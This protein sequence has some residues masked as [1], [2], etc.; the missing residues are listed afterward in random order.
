MLVAA[1]G[2]ATDPYGEDA[3]E[4][5]EEWADAWSSGDQYDTVRFYTTDVTVQS[6]LPDST[7]NYPATFGEGAHHGAGR[8]WLANWLA[9]QTQPH[10][11]SLDAV[12]IDESSAGVLLGVDDLDAVT[13]VSLEM[14][15][16][17]IRSHAAL[18]W[19]D[20]HLPGGAPDP[21][22]AWLDKL[23]ATYVA[24]LDT[25]DGLFIGGEAETLRDAS[26]ALAASKSRTGPA[27]FVV[28]QPDPTLAAIVVE[29]GLSGCRAQL[30][31]EL[32]IAERQ[33]VGEHVMPSIETARRCL[34]DRLGDGGW[35]TALP[36]PAALDQQVT[37][38]VTVSTGSD[39]T[40]INGSRELEEL[41]RWGMSRF[42]AAGLD[43]PPI[44]SVTFGPLPACEGRQGLVAENAAGSPS[45]ILCTDA[46]RACRP[47]RE[48]C[49]EFE[50]ATRFGLL[51]E[52]GHAWLLEHVDEE[53]QDAFLA[54]RSLSTW[55]DTAV[56]WHMRG[57]EHAADM[58][59]WGLM[60]ESLTLT[61]LA[62]PSCEVS[63]AGFVLLADVTA[64]VTCEA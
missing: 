13:F 28:P 47:D 46:D 10:D 37:G 60:D 14:R 3:E 48:T 17:G 58:V 50:V 44:D 55:D 22:L 62:D 30:A 51:H 56:P 38:A 26:I 6:A 34:E 53:T 49:T 31:V 39:I 52:L 15:D 23:I 2:Q 43:P 1:C 8:A 33:I 61:R 29:G 41:V 7:L 32:E 63:A 35:W 21:R 25:P 16:E 64:L 11:R 36:I 18:R 42:T 57:V 40:I 54:A 45:L 27:V 5:L 19:R 20:A 12:F 24:A 59:A 4:Y 9:Y